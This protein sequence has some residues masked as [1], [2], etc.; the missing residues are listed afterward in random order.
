M[1]K[2]WISHVCLVALAAMPATAPAAMDISPA[3]VVLDGAGRELTMGGVAAEN[4]H[5]GSQ[6]GIRPTLEQ[7]VRQAMGIPVPRRGALDLIGDVV[8]YVPVEEGPRTETDVLHLMLPDS[9][10]SPFAAVAL[11]N[12]TFLDETTSRFG[13][14]AGTQIRIGRNASFGTELLMFPPDRGAAA[15]NDKFGDVKFL[16]RLQ[17]GF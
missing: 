2:R 17:I 4:M 8:D 11:E 16:T 6:T 5:A 7:T 12:R 1:M 13:F 9:R 15:E 10:V 3:G 14:G